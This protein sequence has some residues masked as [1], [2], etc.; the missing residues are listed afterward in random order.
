MGLGFGKGSVSSPVP[1]MVPSLSSW[2]MFTIV[3]PWRAA[4]Q[5]SLLP[6]GFQS[7]VLAH[8]PSHSSAQLSI[9]LFLQSASHSSPSPFIH[10]S[11]AYISSYPPT[12]LPASS[13]T[14]N[15][16]SSNLHVCSLLHIPFHP[17]FCPSISPPTHQSIYLGSLLG[18]PGLVSLSPGWPPPLLSRDRQDSL[19]SIFFPVFLLNHLC[20]QVGMCGKELPLPR[21]RE[22]VARV[23]VGVVRGLPCRQHR[24]LCR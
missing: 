6:A 18:C 16:S 5:G 23:W 24:T 21:T 13:H 11:I 1:L 10:S 17:D 14:T 7:L 22:A 15:Y 9:H 19:D 4:G 8:L 20:E 3:V 12:H 2:S